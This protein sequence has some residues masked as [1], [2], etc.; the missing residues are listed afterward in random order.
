MAWKLFWARYGRPLLDAVVYGQKK[1][2]AHRDIK[3]KNVLV[4]EAGVPK[5]ADYGIAKLL[6]NGGS[7]M[8]V[9]GVTFRFDHTEGY[10]P[11]KPEDEKYAYSRDCFAFAAVAISC[12]AGRVIVSEADIKVVL[13]EV[14]LP[15]YLRP[16]IERCLSDEPAERSKR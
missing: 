14:A 5:L 13:Q 6:D 9:S 16:I 8:P 4:T 15:D 2:I 7:W 3:P 1:R 11:S 12:V 10:T